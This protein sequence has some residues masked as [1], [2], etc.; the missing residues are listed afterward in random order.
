MATVDLT[1][2]TLPDAINNNDIVFLDFWASWCGP[3]LSFAPHYE[4]AAKQHP[5][6]VF[7]KINTEQEQ[8]LSASFGITS[9][10]TIMIF[11]EGIGVFSQA[12]ALPPQALTELVEKVRA[13]DMTEVR[14]A[15]EK[16]RAEMAAAQEAQQ[17]EEH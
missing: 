11:R 10:P 1:H 6:I 15:A 13:L 9:I 12:G 8:A 5:D 7:G 3:C 16:Q 14:A 4:A 2:E 17:G